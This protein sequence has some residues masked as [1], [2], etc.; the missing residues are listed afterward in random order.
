MAGKYSVV[1]EQ[2]TS[3]DP[4]SQTVP[5]VTFEVVNNG[6]GTRSGRVT[7]RITQLSATA[8]HDA[9]DGLEV[10]VAV[11]GSRDGQDRGAED[12]LPTLGIEPRASLD[13]TLAQQIVRYAFARVAG[14]SE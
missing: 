8:Q 3:D 9:T 10:S 7:V 5:S 11:K 1:A 2:I 12:L 6:N 13:Q 14:Q 4:E